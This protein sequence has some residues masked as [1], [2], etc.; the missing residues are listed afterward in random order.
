MTDA[1][2]DPGPSGRRI[3]VA[4]DEALIRLDLVEM[5]REEGYDVVGEAGDGVEAVRLVE[6]LRPDVT[7]LDVKMPG[8]D[9]LS[10]AEQI[11]E[12]RLSAIVMLTAF[13]QRELVERARDAGALA[14]VVKPFTRADL[15]PAIEIALSRHSELVALEAEVADLAERFETRKRVDRAKAMLISRLGL[16]EPEAFRWIQKTSMDR[17]LSMREVADAVLS[18]IPGVAP[19][20]P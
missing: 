18:G 13:S 20:S 11:G 5:L 14:Y 17:R 6:E 16:T 2:P 9:G 1:A 19:T 3:V 10:A 12:R 8:L 7:V 15:V 4:E